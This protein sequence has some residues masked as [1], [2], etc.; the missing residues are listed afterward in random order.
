ML[1]DALIALQA[2]VVAFLLLHDWVPLPPLNDV[3]AVQAA[4]TKGRLVIVTI[5]SA[6]PYAYGLAASIDNADNFPNWLW[7]WLAVSYA[8]LVLGAFRAWWLPYFFIREP[9]RVARYQ[10]MFGKTHAFLAERN[11]IR[12]NTLH[13]VFHAAVVAILALLAWAI[14]VLGVM[15]D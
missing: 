3:R 14:F 10:A 13:V 11:G 6:A 9:K 4:D 8:L 12:P 7:A 2:F 15:A 5:L 1:A